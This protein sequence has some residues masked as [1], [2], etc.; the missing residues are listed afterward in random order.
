MAVASSSAK[1]MRYR[2]EISEGVV[3]SGAP[4][5]YRLTNSSIKQTIESASSQ[6]LRADRQKPDST[7][8]AGSVSGNLDIELSFKTHDTFFEALMSGEWDPVGTNGVVTVADAVFDATAHTI[9]SAGAGLPALVKNQWF[10]ISGH[11]TAANNGAFKVSSSVSPTTSSIT[12]D[13]AVKDATTAAAVSVTL[14]GSRLKNGVEPLRTFSIED[15]YSDVS[16]FFMNTGCGISSLTLSLT[17]GALL[18]GVFGVIGRQNSRATTSAFPNIGDEVA[19][20]TTPLINTVNNT[21][22]LLDGQSLGDSCS[23]SFN[24]TIGTGMR[25]RRCLGSGIGASGI[26]TGTFDIKGSMSLYFG[27]SESAAVYDK[28]IAD[29]PISFCISCFDANGDGYVFTFERAKIINSAV[30]SGSINTDV[31][32]SME[33]DATVGPNTSAMLTIDRLGSVA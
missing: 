3:P 14:S 18:T 29:Q 28:M 23:E 17:T 13:T 25:E 33:I 2:E 31:M 5:L 30:E 15:E 16:Q 6:E 21:V 11:T 24:L 7:L 4:Q 27:A 10:K 12:L 1:Q 8:V 20:T 9:T 32:M 22:V 19:A 26:A